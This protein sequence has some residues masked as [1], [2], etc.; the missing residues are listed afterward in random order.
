MRVVEPMGLL[1]GDDIVMFGGFF[2]GIANV[3][4]HTYARSVTKVNDIW[5]RMDDIPLLGGLTHAAE[6]AVGR[7]V[8][9]CGGYSVYPGPHRASCFVYDHGKVPGS[10]Q[11]SNF[12]SL[13]VGSAGAG[14]IYDAALNALF[15]AGGRQS[16]NFTNPGTLDVT[17]TWKYSFSSPSVGWMASTPIPYEANHQS[18]VTHTDAFGNQRHFYAGGQERLFE[19]CRNRN[20]TYEFMPQTE[21][22][23]KRASM[24]LA[25]GHATTSTRAIG[26]GF[27]MAGGSVNSLGDTLNRTSDMSYYDIP[28]D[29]WT[30]I[31][32]VPFAGATPVVV[33]P[34]NGY[35]HFVNQRP[36]SSRQRIAA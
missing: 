36:N 13:P 31:G 4:N 35:I 15:Y 25:R 5:R 6:V 22:W 3:T 34:S 16:Y 23:V 30:K 19:C 17:N 27:I 26:C 10:K 9:L 32:E 8:Y 2:N 18:A 29:H 28:S 33:I 14:M 20:E 1:V 7:K 11:W 12:P 21:T 24:P